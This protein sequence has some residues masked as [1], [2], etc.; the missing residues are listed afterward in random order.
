MKKLLL[1]GIA[2]LLIS[3]QVMFSQNIGDLNG[4]YYQ[5]VALD[6]E[7]K[8]I[9]GMDIVA[10]P[11]FEREIG[12]RFT[13]TKGLDGT[14]QWE[15][16]HTVTTDQYGL[17]G[18]VIGQGESTGVASYTKLL[19]IPW[20]DAD[21]FLKVEI[22]TNNNGTYKLVSNQ[23][24]MTVPYAFYADDIAD[25]AIT[26][27]KIL[28]ET[29]L[30][31]DIGTGSVESSE[32]LD[33]TILAEDIKTGAVT[34]EEILDATILNEDIADATIDLTTKVT[35]IMPTANGGTGIDASAVTDGQI[36]VGDATTGT[37][38]STNIIGS[39]GITI[40]EAPGTI[41]I[42]SVIGGVGA[43]GS[44]TSPV[45]S[46]GDINAGEAWL[47]NNRAETRIGPD[48]DKP[49]E[50][51]DILLVSANEDLKGC[52]MSTYIESVDASGVAQVKVVIFNPS[53]ITVTL[54]HSMTFKFLH[55]K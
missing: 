2:L 14:A 7:A 21:Q 26:T 15:E 27:A 38:T 13:I 39:G 19:D 25:D 31:E 29:I 34:S 3:T 23:G 33:E 50:M 36:L 16:T 42:E 22:S 9:V 51:G 53:N 20:I 52:I 11:L 28:N 43:D 46:N 45:G 6:D 32:I 37:Y 41:T 35:G 48:P 17:F 8:E 49:Y 47:S 30:A 54:E 5:A 44:F 4:I 24:F 40:T 55:V 10:K 1:V 12:V 18:L